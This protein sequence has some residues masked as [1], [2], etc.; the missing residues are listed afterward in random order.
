VLRREQ[1]AEER[2]AKAAAVAPRHVSIL[3]PGEQQRRATWPAADHQQ[4]RSVG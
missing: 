2:A 4:I 3:P 1:E